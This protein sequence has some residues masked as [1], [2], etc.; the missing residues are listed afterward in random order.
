MS[1]EHHLKAQYIEQLTSKY[2]S[3]LHIVLTNIKVPNMIHLWFDDH[4]G[5][6]KLF[7]PHYPLEDQYL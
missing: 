3:Y 2:F 5:Q 1:P 6:F 7:H 4:F